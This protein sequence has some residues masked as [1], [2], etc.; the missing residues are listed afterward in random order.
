MDR[1]VHSCVAGMIKY[2]VI[3]KRQEDVIVYG[4]D[5]LFSSVLE[6][7][8]LLLMGIILG[9][10]IYTI[11]LLLTFIP[12]Q[13]FG[14]GFHCQ[15]HLRCFI[16]MI[17][18]YLFAVYVLIELPV[19]ILWGGAVLN[20]VSFLK[21]APVENV[22]APF[23]NKFKLKM[24]RYVLTVYFIILTVAVIVSREQLELAKSFLSAVILSGVSIMCVQRVPGNKF[25]NNEISE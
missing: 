2:K 10:G 4:L 7:V 3:E 15:T 1:L 23:S 25:V 6:M 13:S 9:K 16:T 19:V 24:R 8:G 18:G 14:G 21:F 11:C 20:I 12:L 5:L 17:T 22:K